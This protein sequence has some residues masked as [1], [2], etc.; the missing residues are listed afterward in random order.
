[1]G[2]VKNTGQGEEHTEHWDDLIRVLDTLSDEDITAVRTLVEELAQRKG[3]AREAQTPYAVSTGAIEKVACLNE[4][5]WE[6][7]PRPAT[8][9]SALEFLA[10]GPPGF[11]PGELDQLLADIER[12]REMELDSPCQNT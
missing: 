7:L 4:S 1:M 8:T 9:E 12:L 5:D 2:V 10:S 3:M 6:T 11:L